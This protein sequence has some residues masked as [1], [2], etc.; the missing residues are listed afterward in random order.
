MNEN[1]KKRVYFDYNV[2]VNYINLKEVKHEIEKKQDEFKYI[3]SPAFL[4]E[5]ANIKGDKNRI[6]TYIA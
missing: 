2:F 4:E 1:I 3:C 5:V 6:K